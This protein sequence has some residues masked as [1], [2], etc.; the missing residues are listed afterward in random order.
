M[1]P[2]TNPCTVER[3]AMV[4]PRELDKLLTA[5]GARRDRTAFALLFDHFGPRVQAYLRR[6]GLEPAPAAELT[7]DVME[8]LWRKAHLFDAR[9]ASAAT[10]VFRV[11]RNRRIDLHRRSRA[12]AVAAEDFWTIADPNEDLNQWVD[13]ARREELV[14]A[15]LAALPPEQVTLVRLAFFEGLSHSAIAERMALPLGT[16]KSRI[17]LA[18]SRLRRLLD[19]PGG[20]RGG[21]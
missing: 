6:L 2:A 17:R 19:D 15:A 8:V 9:K 21:V 13:A 5:V 10:W 20:P 12:D 14:R 11:A 4:G 7:Q 3:A 1:G 16:V 18:F